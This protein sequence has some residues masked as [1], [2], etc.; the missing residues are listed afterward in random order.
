MV[1]DKF[2][3]RFRKA[4][5]LRLVSHHDLMR[6]F[7]RM[8]RRAELPFHST[9]G[10]NPRPRLI[11]A[12]SLGLGIVGCQEV[13]ELELDAELPAE[14]VQT[15]LARQAPPGLDI[16]EVRRVDVRAGAQ[17]Q[18][19]TYRLPVPAERRSELPERITALLSQSECWIERSRPQP[20][21]YDLR[22][23]LIALRLTAEA[24]EMDLRVTPTGSARPDEVLTLLGM[25]DLLDA[26]AVLQRTVLELADESASWERKQPEETQLP[27]VAY[28]PS[29]PC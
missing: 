28:A 22:P 9:S 26:G 20:R 6:T 13:A 12:L 8:L 5:D 25:H 19:A 17:V 24:L 23:Y 15:R 4:G 27:P 29:S 11:F 7:E 1:R 2:R 14:E 16:L 21:R 10:F 3:I 18:R